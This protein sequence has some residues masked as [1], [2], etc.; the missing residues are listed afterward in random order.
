[1]GRWPIAPIPIAV[2]EGDFSEPEVRAIFSA[3]QTWNQFYKNSQGFSL[4][5]TG[6]PAGVAVSSKTLSNINSL[7]TQGI[8]SE[9]Q[10]SGQVVIYK[11]DTWA[12]DPTIIAVTSHC[13]ISDGSSF[14]QFYMAAM[15]LNYQ[16]YFTSGNK[17]PDFQ[18]ILLHELGHLAGLGHSC[19][20]ESGTGIPGCQSSPQEYIEAALFPIVYFPDG[21][22]GEV[23]RDLASNDQGRANCLYSD[24]QS[25]Q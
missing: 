15:E 11:R 19:E 23:R 1:M 9:D 7:C 3:A 10:Y 20:G 25:S 22:H 24:V 4:V 2:H 21:V 13:E 18:S 5:D 12:Y 14:S 17:V 16:Y 8:I 6:D